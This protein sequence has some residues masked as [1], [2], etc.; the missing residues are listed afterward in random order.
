MARRCGERAAA[1]PWCP[2]PLCSFEAL[3]GCLV[4]EVKNV[5]PGWGD[6][7]SDLGCIVNAG[8]GDVVECPQNLPEE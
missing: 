7:L 5:C 6:A 3:Y 8:G 1:Q 4:L 2:P